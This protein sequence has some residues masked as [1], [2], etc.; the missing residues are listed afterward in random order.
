MES[1]ATMLVGGAVLIMAAVAAATM[2]QLAAGLPLGRMRRDWYVLFAFI[3]CFFLGYLSYLF[4]A[5]DDYKEITDL[6]APAM[7]FMGAAFVV[8]VARIMLR[9]TQELLQL[10]SLEAESVTD[11]LTGLSNRRAFDRR[12]AVEAARARRIG[13][14]LALLVIDIDHFKD[15]NDTYG[16]AVG[17]RVLM[18]VGRLI[19]DGLRTTDIAARFGGEE[20]AIVAPHTAS[21]SAVVLA[22]RVRVAVERE[23][24]RALGVSASER[25]IT[26]SIGVAGSE[27]PGAGDEATFERADKA[28]YEAKRGGRNR[29]ILA[30]STKAKGDAPEVM[31]SKPAMGSAPT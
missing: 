12:W 18:Q 19:Q 23:A 24:C 9:T 27:Q 26:V 4:I 5:H 2:S 14:P 7:F 6:I 3:G 10:S 17:D 8:L 28:L 13:S 15:V 25:A 21:Q 20:F 22:E 1:I 31:L 30:P 16:H 11:P 29:V